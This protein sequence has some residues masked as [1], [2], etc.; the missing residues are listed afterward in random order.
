MTYAPLCRLRYLASEGVA[1]NLF[2]VPISSRHTGMLSK[3][4]RTCAS[5]ISISGAE[6]PT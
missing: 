1:S 3:A 6:R 5:K 4:W 2:S